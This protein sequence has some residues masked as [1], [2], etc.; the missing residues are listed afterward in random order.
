MRHVF[1]AGHVPVQ[2]LIGC[3]PNN[4]GIIMAA[5]GILEMKQIGFMAANPDYKVN[6][7]GTKVANFR[8]ITNVFWND[9]DAERQE[10]PEG[11]RYELWGDSA[12]NFV[13][14][15][16]QGH[17]VYVES[18]PRNNEYVDPTTGEKRYNI[19]FV[20]NK[21]LILEKKDASQAQA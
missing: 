14:I 5:N 16:K 2:Y 17:R 18:E 21:W 1:E 20:V 19:R 4:G 10:R 9:K 13:K 15:V 11:F 12:E 6:A 3:K 7:N 8:V